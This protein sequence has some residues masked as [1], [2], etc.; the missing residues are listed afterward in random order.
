MI[1]KK[2]ETNTLTTKMKNVKKYEKKNFKTIVITPPG[3]K[4]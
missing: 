2:M 4:Q 1:L 3:W